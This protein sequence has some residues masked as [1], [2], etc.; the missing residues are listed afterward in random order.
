MKGI[1]E[2]LMGL[3]ERDIEP[4]TLDYYS[5]ATASARMR[6]DISMGEGVNPFDRELAFGN[7]VEGTE[8]GPNSED[9]IKYLSRAMESRSA[10]IRV[11]RKFYTPKPL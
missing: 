7:P 3:P 6:R 5:P 10:R 11:I 9:N 2:A 8:F 1:G 4:K